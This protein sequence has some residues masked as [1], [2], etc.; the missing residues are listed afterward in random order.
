[1]EETKSELQRICECIC[2]HQ[3]IDIDKVLSVLKIDENC[4][5][6]YMCKLVNRPNT[7]NQLPNS[8]LI[9][10]AR[11]AIHPDGKISVSEFDFSDAA[12]L[13]IEQNS[14]VRIGNVTVDYQQNKLVISANPICK[15]DVGDKIPEFTHAYNAFSACSGN[16][17]YW[18]DRQIDAD[19]MLRINAST[20][21][22]SG[23]E[24]TIKYE[25]TYR[26]FLSDTENDTVKYKATMDVQ[27]VYEI[28]ASGVKYS[29][30]VSFD[31]YAVRILT[32]DFDDE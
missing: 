13:S 21:R 26:S 8:E 30:Q 16:I 31:P 12:N 20:T 22:Y 23:W 15:Y 10:I 3:S 9:T 25:F 17:R 4:D 27:L 24:R 7:I 19:A 32:N 5:L 18:N 6:A 2:D 28:C 1:M 11:K 29:Y 14:K